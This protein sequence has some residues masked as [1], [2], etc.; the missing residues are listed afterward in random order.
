MPAIF[1]MYMSYQRNIAF[2]QMYGEI[3]DVTGSEKYI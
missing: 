3:L 2:A 1:L